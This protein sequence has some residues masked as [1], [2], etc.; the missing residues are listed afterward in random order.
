MKRVVPNT[1][2]TLSRLN[3]IDAVPLPHC[4]YFATSTV[5]YAI[6]ARLLSSKTRQD[7]LRDAPGNWQKKN[8]ELVL[9][10]PVTIPLPDLRMSWL[11]I[12]GN[13]LGESIFGCAAAWI[14]S[15][16]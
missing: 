4:S 14:C 5:D 1:R 3:R 9:Q 16:N 13:Y 8:L 11:P 10:T 12:T 15:A 7:G 2:A 6:V